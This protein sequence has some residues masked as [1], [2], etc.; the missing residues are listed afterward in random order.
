MALWLCCIRGAL[1]QA[2]HIAPMAFA[3]IDITVY[4]E[5]NMR[6]R[7]PRDN[8]YAMIASLLAPPIELH[9][10]ILI[11]KYVTV[12]CRYFARIQTS[13]TTSV[14]PVLRIPDGSEFF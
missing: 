7:P 13:A 4:I 8:I 10:K 6:G 11:R 9:E 14:D 2:I 3:S 1:L 5:I 12:I